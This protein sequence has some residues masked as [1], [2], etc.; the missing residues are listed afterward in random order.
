MT[1]RLLNGSLSG[2]DSVYVSFSN[3]IVNILKKLKEFG[4]INDYLYPCDM[5]YKIQVFLK[6][7]Q[8]GIPAFRGRKN[9]SIPSRPMYFKAKN[10]LIRKLGRLS[11]IFVSTSKGI[12]GLNSNTK[13]EVGGL[14]LF[15]VCA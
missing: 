13:P 12:M 10:K 11:T 5:K 15:E 3:E 7:D 8:N 4:Y 6:Y 9:H 1:T 2:R 14:L